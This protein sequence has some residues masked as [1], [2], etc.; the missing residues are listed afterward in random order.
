MV[1]VSHRMR[2]AAVAREVAGRFAYAVDE[3]YRG[4]GLTRIEPQNVSRRI[5]EKIEN[6]L[7]FRQS[8]GRS[9]RYAVL[10]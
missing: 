9:Q 6:L 8:Q 4:R 3:P 1:V 2:M 5:F 7:H 10:S